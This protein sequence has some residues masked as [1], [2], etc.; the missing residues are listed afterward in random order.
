MTNKILILFV[1]LIVAPK[2]GAC[3]KDQQMFLAPDNWNSERL[4]F[5][6][7]FAPTLDLVG[8]EDIRFSPDWA[9]STKQG[10][11]TYTFVW[12]NEKPYELSETNLIESMEAYFDGLMGLDPEKVK[13][14]KD[15][16]KTACVMAKSAYGFHGKIIT[17]D[18][19]FTK[20]ELVLF[21]RLKEI[22]CDK[23][24]KQY[25]LFELSPK[26]YTHEIWRIFE[27]VKLITECD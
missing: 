20:K 16:D 7:S 15:K 19:F 17:H 23:S 8:F 27:D 1:L 3:Q 18:A 2:S 12:V 26:A 22:K 10:F 5:P 24:S 6:L 25:V 11:W 14:S 13:Y 21:V 9:D 4:E